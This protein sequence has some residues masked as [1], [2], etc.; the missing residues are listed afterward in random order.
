M[1]KALTGEMLA[2]HPEPIDKQQH[3]TFHR[4]VKARGA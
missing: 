4:R 1:P 2:D 3:Y